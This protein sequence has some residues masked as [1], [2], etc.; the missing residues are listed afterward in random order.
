MKR[1]V[2]F[3]LTLLVCLARLLPLS[4]LCASEVLPSQHAVMDCRAK[5]PFPFD[6]SQFTKKRLSSPPEP[7]QASV[8]ASPAMQQADFDQ[9]SFCLNQWL[10]VPQPDENAAA[11][12]AAPAAHWVACAVE[13][14]VFHPPPAR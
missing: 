9:A 4:A 7:E 14:N 6:A 3:C 11:R 12:P 5:R 8:F 13:R 2:L 1:R 10:L